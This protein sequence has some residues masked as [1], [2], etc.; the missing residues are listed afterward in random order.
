MIPPAGMI[1]MTTLGTALGPI[2]TLAVLAALVTLA[3]LVTSL[4][5]ERRVVATWRGLATVR[6]PLPASHHYSPAR[7]A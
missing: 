6:R 3:V 7:A 1:P 4:V 2:A 5:G